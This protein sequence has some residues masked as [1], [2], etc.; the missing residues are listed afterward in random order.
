[1]GAQRHE[2][3]ELRVGICQGCPLSPLVFAIAVDVLLRRLVRKIPG[4][5]VRAYADDIAAVLPDGPG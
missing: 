4:I 2:G 1:M 5:L 3:F